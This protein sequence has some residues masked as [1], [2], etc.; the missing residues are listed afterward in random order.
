[1]TALEFASGPLVLSSDPRER[2]ADDYFRRAK[3]R[4][5]RPARSRVSRR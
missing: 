3:A 1:M 4:Q 2:E 5:H